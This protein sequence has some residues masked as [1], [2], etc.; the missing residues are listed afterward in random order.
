MERKE[1]MAWKPSLKK[2]S[3]GVESAQVVLDENNL[4]QNYKLTKPWQR[5]HRRLGDGPPFMR[6]GRMIRY[7]RDQV[8]KWLAEHEVK[9]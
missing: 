5:K 3:A 8:E 6:I 2:D 9:G 1:L 4:D 7:R